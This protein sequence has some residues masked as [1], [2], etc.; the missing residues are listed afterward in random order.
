[1]KLFSTC[2]AAIATLLLVSP[3][4]APQA[5][6]QTGTITSAQADNMARGNAL[7]SLI[8]TINSKKVKPGDSVTLKTMSSVTL[9]NGT[10]LP[11]GATLTGT[12]TSV[13]RPKGHDKT[14]KISFTIDTAHVHG[15]SIPVHVLV[16]AAKVPNLVLSADGM[17][18]T[19]DMTRG[20]VMPDAGA[21][22]A[23][24]RQMMQSAEGQE[25]GTNSVKHPHK[26]NT[27]TIRMQGSTLQIV[28]VPVISLKGAT[29]SSTTAG[30]GEATFV[31][32]KDVDLENGTLMRIYI[33][34][35]Q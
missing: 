23:Q 15:N 30:K 11:R 31:D 10:S 4:L 7:A 3:G 5:I 1:M 35:A 12:I 32:K 19:S 20:N 16:T 27:G 24:D 22:M 25:T 2:A 8:R 13:E 9:S 17:P 6:A 18:I 26:P 34:P 33:S 29:L 28:D 21:G 14:A